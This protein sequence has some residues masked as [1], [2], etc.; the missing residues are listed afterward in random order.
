MHISRPHS[1]QLLTLHLLA[2]S[3]AQYDPVKDF[4]RRFGHQSAVVDNKLYVDGGSVNWKPFTESSQNYTNTFF[5]YSDLSGE[6]HGMP[7]QY[8]TLSKNATVPSVSGGVLWADAVNKRLYLFGG[9]HRQAPPPAR[10]TL[11]GYD[12]LHDQ[13]DASA[14]ADTITPTSYG[15]G[16][17]VAGRGEAYYYGGWA[18]NASAAG[19]GPGPPRAS[20][21][22]VRY[23]MDANAWSS[24]A[25]PDAVARADGAMVYIP[26]GGA[27]MLVY[28]GGSADLHGN[29]TAAPQPLDEVFLYDIAGA[30][31]YA[32]ATSGH[33]PT[34]RRRFCGGATWAQDQSSYN[35]YIYG[36]AGFPPNTT[37]YDDIHILTIP[38]FQWIRGAD[39]A[40]G[41]TSK[42][43]PKSMMTCN[44]VNGGQMLVVGGAFADTN[45]TAGM[46]DDAEDAGGQ[47]NVALGESDV[48]AAYQ[49][50][51]TT[52]AVP[53]DIRA[54]VGGQATGGATVTAPA[55][56]FDAPGL[57][58]LM[59]RTAAV[60][61]RSPTRSVSAPSTELAPPAASGLSVGGIA[62]IA[63]GGAVLVVGV[64]AAGCCC[65]IRH[66]QKHYRGP[67]QTGPEYRR[68]RRCRLW[69]ITRTRDRRRSRP[70]HCRLARPSSCRPT[71]CTS[72]TSRCS[73]N[74]NAATGGP[75][76][77][78]T[79]TTSLRRP[80]AAETLMPTLTPSLLPPSPLRLATH[81]APDTLASA[82]EDPSPVDPRSPWVKQQQQ[83][84]STPP[85]TPIRSPRRSSGAASG[86]RGPLPGS[87]YFATAPLL[88]PVEFPPYQPA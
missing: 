4:C 72:S 59:T 76:T 28:L 5:L 15:A 62:G 66:R 19:W 1:L 78:T 32:Q 79:P 26:A 2:L 56:G 37:G 54:A 48:W 12:I 84:P 87:P 41:N 83:T 75:A 88:P 47:H 70:C 74:T 24:L 63:A 49:P 44:V 42:P 57:S 8:A 18:S 55:T 3:A 11:Y 10:A 46:C 34:A 52:Y 40:G 33:T 43:F 14:P 17:S 61:T 35:I 85:R 86:S 25:G 77:P 20:S 69:R 64:L 22:L 27:G 65:V 73:S 45:A 9:D 53:P 81:C 13:W 30:R 21:R 31:W 16:V 29:G 60:A 80:S 39:S 38:S 71:A 50:A 23:A 58:V 6:M 36:G 7:P 67:R 68:P 82:A 51:L